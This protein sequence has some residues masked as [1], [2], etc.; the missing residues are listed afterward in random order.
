[1][2]ST[3]DEINPHSLTKDIV[4]AVAGAVSK[5]KLISGRIFCITEL[6]ESDGSS[7]LLLATSE[8]LKTWDA[9]GLLEYAKAVGHP[10]LRE[11]E[12]R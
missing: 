4:G 12:E 5:H 10:L 7:S 11:Q 2:S 8:G 1:M 3:P 6:Y 9:L